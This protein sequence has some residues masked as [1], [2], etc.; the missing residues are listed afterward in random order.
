MGGGRGE[1][2]GR[3]GYLLGLVSSAPICLIEG[4]AA[5][6]V[7]PESSY[8][9]PSFCSLKGT[10]LL[11]AP[12]SQRSFAPSFGPSLYQSWWLGGGLHS[13]PHCAEVRCG[14]Q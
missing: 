13:C 8:P 11:L 4:D 3:K 9:T 7:S 6:L 12:R 1:R 10:D 5:P 2:R 14:R